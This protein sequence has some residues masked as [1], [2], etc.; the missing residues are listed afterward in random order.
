[1]QK[2]SVK[3]AKPPI[4]PENRII[5][6]GKICSPDGHVKDKVSTV[7]V[8]PTILKA[9]GLSPDALEAVKAEKT[10]SLPEIEFV[11]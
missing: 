5:N 6:P 10:A 1:M 2:P 7:S 11:K 3:C 8:A 4:K 9:L